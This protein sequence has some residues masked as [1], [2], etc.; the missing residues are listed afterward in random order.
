MAAPFA[1]K[2]VG[3]AASLV[4]SIKATADA[5]LPR[6]GFTAAAI[7][8][9]GGDPS[10]RQ[11]TDRIVVPAANA[12]GV[13]DNANLADFFT[14]A[15]G[16]IAILP[17]GTWRLTSELQIALSNCEIRG[18]PGL[19]K[20]TGNFGFRLIRLLDCN[21]VKISGITFDNQYVNATEDQGFG[22]LWSQGNTLTD[23]TIEKCYFTVPN[24]NTNAIKFN[25]STA[26]GGLANAR[27]YQR[28][29]IVDSTFKDVGR[30]GIEYLNHYL[31]GQI[32]LFDLSVERNR[33]ENCGLSGSYGMSAS[34]SGLGTGIRANYNETI[35]PLG[36]GIEFA[37]PSSSEAIGNTF[38]DVTRTTALIASSVQSG[39]AND[40]IWCD[41]LTISRNRTVGTNL[42]GASLS[43]GRTRNSLVADNRLTLGG[44]V[45]LIGCQNV[46]LQSNTF[47]CKGIYGI[48]ARAGTD[49]TAT[50]VP[51]TDNTIR[52]TIVDCSGAT[53]G[54]FISCVTWDGAT[55]QRNK[56][57]G[58]K[59]IRPGSGSR[60]NRSNGAS[61]NC[62][63]G[64][65]YDTT[66]FNNASLII[67][68]T[69]GPA[70]F[71]LTPEQAQWPNLIFRGALTANCQVFTDPGPDRTYTVKNE[72]TGG[73]LIDFRPASGNIGI[74]VASGAPRIIATRNASL[75]SIL[76]GTLTV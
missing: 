75:D 76:M 65:D 63:Q 43:I 52:D 21:N 37:R 38:R 50:P 3:A 6:S 59:V 70:T 55:T 72:T 67:T 40:A 24:A 39:A 26:S 27:N 16:N 33:F 56:M 35:N 51:C 23:L 2:L 71:T 54:T 36:I 47:A 13:N 74:S 58:G 53:S 31:D 46:A 34:F 1:A 9:A 61:L 28:V 12:T 8:A 11:I 29:S 17:A 25:A 73:F 20:I 60:M 57:I 44:Y 32:R 7:D 68:I 49:S 4:A 22:I 41:G 14:R 18:V 5:A 19:T 42:A 69:G 62:M 64:T 15:P 10:A 30:M 45:D 48:L 66:V